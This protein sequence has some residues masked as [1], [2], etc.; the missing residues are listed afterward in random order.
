[1]ARFGGVA[2]ELDLAA[3][4]GTIINPVAHQGQ[5]EGGLMFGIGAA[6][7]EELTIQDGQVTTATLGDYKLPT[8]MDIPPFRTI[9]A[10]RPR[11]L[12]G[13]AAAAGLQAQRHRSPRRRAECGGRDVPAGTAAASTVL[14]LR[15]KVMESR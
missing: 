13:C 7:M 14:G 3:D 15:R 11:L 10:G 4:V 2:D 12:C 5:L 9:A 8:A 1:M 6:L